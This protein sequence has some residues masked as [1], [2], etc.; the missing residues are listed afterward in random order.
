[1]VGPIVEADLAIQM[2]TDEHLA[3]CHG[4]AKPLLFDLENA[5]VV[6]NRVVV[7]N[8][9][10]FLTREDLLEIGSLGRHKGRLFLFRF[11]R[12]AFIVKIDPFLPEKTICFLQ[13]GKIVESEFLG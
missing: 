9:P 6:S 4:I 3:A 12:K 8:D 7:L 10:I 11:D 5:S 1:M 2:L 13:S